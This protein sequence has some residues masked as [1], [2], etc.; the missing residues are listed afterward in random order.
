MRSRMP[1]PC[2][3][4]SAIRCCSSRHSPRVCRAS[5]G[6][7]DTPASWCC[8]ALPLGGRAATCEKPVV[9]AGT[10]DSRRRPRRAGSL[11]PAA[12]L[13]VHPAAGRYQSSFAGCGRHPIPVGPAVEP[14]PADVHH[15]LRSGEVVLARTIYLRFAAGRPR[16][17][18]LRAG[19]GT[20]G[21]GFHPAVFVSACSC[22]AWS[23]TANWCG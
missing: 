3:R 21:Q 7:R 6:R 10:V 19:E 1:A 22:A 17:H 8:A 2:S 5:A 16:R 14:L 11:G 15:L 13:R 4:C 18:G 9:E 12:G 20:R 23:A